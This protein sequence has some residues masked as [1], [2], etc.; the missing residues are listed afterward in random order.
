MDV[1]S[2]QWARVVDRLHAGDAGEV[3][4]LQRAAYLTEAQAHDD[5]SLPPLTQMTCAP[6][7]PVPPCLLSVSA[8]RDGWWRPCASRLMTR[9][10]VL[11]A[12]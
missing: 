9:S 7:L 12:S 2:P 10:V 8:I 3:L 6:S 11:E 1:S 4:T 5:L